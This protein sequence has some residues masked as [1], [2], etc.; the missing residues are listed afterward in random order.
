MLPVFASVT[1]KQALYYQCCQESKAAWVNNPGLPEHAWIVPSVLHELGWECAE[2]RTLLPARP[3]AAL[4]ILPH[5]A[6]LS[7]HPFFKKKKLSHKVTGSLCLSFTGRLP[8]RSSLPA[9]PS[10]LLVCF[11]GV[12]S[13]GQPTFQCSGAG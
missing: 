7:P 6:Q 12:Q 1:S 9:T 10:L 11:P 2:N 13:P 5:S 4:N 3:G 8:S